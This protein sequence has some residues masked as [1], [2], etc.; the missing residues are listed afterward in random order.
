MLVGLVMVGKGIIFSL[1]ILTA[2]MG[3]TFKV[4]I[5]IYHIKS[6]LLSVLIDQN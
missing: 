2:S 3:L 6:G 5:N 1:F 4:E